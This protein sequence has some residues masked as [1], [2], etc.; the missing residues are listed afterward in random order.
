MVQELYKK[1]GENGCYLFCLYDVALEYTYEVRYPD[2]K[3]VAFFIENGW[4]SDDMFVKNPE[5]IL[6]YLTGVY[7]NVE[8]RLCVPEDNKRHY[9]IKCYSYKNVTH[10]CRTNF[11]PLDKSNCKKNRVYDSIRVCTPLDKKTI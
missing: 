9:I 4:L 5:K 6:K 7:W 11:D 8:K 1:L 10:F 3:D 2:Y